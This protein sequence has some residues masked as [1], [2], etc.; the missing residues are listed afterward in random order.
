VALEKFSNTYILLNTYRPS[1]TET[2][3]LTDEFGNILTDE[4]GNILGSI[5]V[6]TT[7]YPLSA[8]SSDWG[9]PLVLPAVFDFA[10]IEKYYLFFDYVEQYDNTVLDGVLDFDNDRTTVAL[11]AVNVDIF[12]HMSM[13]V[14]Y[15]TLLPT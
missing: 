10:D 1:T 2:I 13:D 7:N 8:Y 11:S 14:L 12:K 4:F 15:Q 3:P 6:Y 5:Y 9:W